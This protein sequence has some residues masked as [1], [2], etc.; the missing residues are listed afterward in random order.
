M[1]GSG[2]SIVKNDG[3]LVLLL[4]SARFII[5]DAFTRRIATESLTVSVATTHPAERVIP[6]TMRH[7]RALHPFIVIQIVVIAADAACRIRR[8]WFPTWA[9]RVEKRI[10]PGDC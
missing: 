4:S 6:P 8:E 10:M 3:L 1:R 2:A 7:L 9:F 5:P